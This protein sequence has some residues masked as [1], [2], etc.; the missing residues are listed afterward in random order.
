MEEKRMTIELAT[1][2][3]EDAKNIL[4]MLGIEQEFTM[5]V[6]NGKFIAESDS[7]IMTPRMFK[8]LK[9]RATIMYSGGK[10]MDKLPYAKVILEYRYKM[11]GGGSNSA[12]IAD[13]SYI[14]DNDID[15]KL[16]KF[17]HDT[18]TRMGLINRSFLRLAE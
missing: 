12:F 3:L 7:I 11:F 5:T 1:C 14:I 2:L 13:V 15:S 10:Y 4:L 8:E 9:V 17:S 16:G 6:E 18:L